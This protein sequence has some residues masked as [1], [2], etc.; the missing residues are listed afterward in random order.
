MTVLTLPSLRTLA[1]PLPAELL[2]EHAVAALVEE[3]ELTPKP[4]L[5]DTCGNGAHRDLDLELMRAS[6]HALRP[7]FVALARAACGRRP[8]LELR[9]RLAAIGRAGERAMLAATGGANAHRGAIWTLG[10][11][12]AAAAMSEHASS[13][14]RLC[15]VAA[16]IARHPDPFA[17]AIPTNG[18]RVRDRFGVPGARGEAQAGFPHV[19]EVALP[20][21]RAARAAGIPETN[22]RLDALVAVIA[23]LD[24]T[25]VLHRGGARALV[26][27]RR[28]AAAVIDAGGTSTEAGRRALRR[29]DEVLLAFNASPGG[30]ADLLA[31]ALFLDRIGRPPAEKEV[32][33]NADDQV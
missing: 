2:A 30:A 12:V 13:A 19:V 7:T 27:A 29:L 28:G 16:A 14:R 9:V 4:G 25:C 23:R 17:P 3:A 1:A 33:R 22:A 8:G 6:A 5:V 15:A 26:A 31:A 11:L 10:L 24:D 21:L 32:T 18:G 20:A